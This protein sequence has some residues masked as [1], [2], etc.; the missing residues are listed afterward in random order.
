MGILPSLGGPDLV[1]GVELRQFDRA[2]G[3]ESGMWRN[4]SR[5]EGDWRRLLEEL[6]REELETMVSLEP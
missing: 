6:T 3:P 5:E 1:A 2:R 4:G